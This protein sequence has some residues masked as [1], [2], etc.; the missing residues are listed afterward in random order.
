MPDPASG[1]AAATGAVAMTT[2]TMLGLSH[3]MPAGASFYEFLWGCLFAI[4]GACAYQ[5]I[6]AQ[7][8]RQR[9]AD[10]GVAIPDRPRI[11]IVM[12]GYSACGA[13]MAAACLIYVI[14]KAGGAT[15]FGDTTWLQSAA[16]Y[17]VAGAAGPPIVFKVVG[18]FT[19]LMSSSKSGEKP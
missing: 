2:G 15:G 3:V 10:Q 11:D 4:L 8:A 12:L 18:A 5:F 9:A 6:R 13:P 17:M 19:A 1:T 16:G 14:H 7:D